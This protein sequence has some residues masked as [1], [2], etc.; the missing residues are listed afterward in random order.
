M[1]KQFSFGDFGIVISDNPEITSCIFEPDI[2]AVIKDHMHDRM[3][4]KNAYD[5]LMTQYPV[6]KEV[7]FSL[8]SKL[9]KE[10]ITD[11]DWFIDYLDEEYKK[12]YKFSL[13][14]EGWVTN[15]K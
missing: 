6:I 8:G 4:F 14:E 15:A 10:I 2:D 7:A 9:N 11:I 12:D 1:L 3:L 5:S 13:A